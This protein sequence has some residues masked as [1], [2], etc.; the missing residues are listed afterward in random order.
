MLKNGWKTTEFWVA[1]AAT[2]LLTVQQALWPDNPFPKTE[3]AVLVT[4]IIARLGEKTLGPV[5]AEGKRAWQTSEFWV[6]IGFTFI[7]Q[8]IDL[9]EN[10]VNLV[11][12]WVIGR[13]AVKVA[14]NIDLKSVLGKGK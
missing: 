11:Y 13:P 12:A 5:D 3:F 4:W 9:P 1:L 6:A 8:F 10:V 14:K 2:V 7:R